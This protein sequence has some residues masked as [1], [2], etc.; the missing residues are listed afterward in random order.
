MKQRNKCRIIL[1]VVTAILCVISRPFRHLIFWL[2][3]GFIVL[4]VLYKI[5]V[6]RYKYLFKEK[7]L[8]PTDDEEDIFPWDDVYKCL[9]KPFL[10]Q[11]N[12][13]CPHCGR[14][15]N[16]LVWIYYTSPDWTWEDLCGRE[17][18]LSL[19]PKCK[20]Q[21]EFKCSVMN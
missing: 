19:C 10:P 7:V 6:E 5:R 14:S 13:R 17:G 9:N 1:A 8:N 3:G 20:K 11:G 21:I 4:Y 15:S 16:R 18:W 12:K 2:G